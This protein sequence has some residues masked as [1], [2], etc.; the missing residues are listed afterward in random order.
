MTMATLSLDLL[1]TF[2]EIQESGGFSRAAARLG[3]TQS[4]VSLQVQRLEAAV[5]TPLFRRQGKRR[6]LTAEGEVLLHYARRMLALEQQALE[7]V[8]NQQHEG[9]VRIGFAQDFAESWLPAALAQ[10]ARRH[11]KVALDARVDRNVALAQGIE[12]GTLDVALAL[13]LDGRRVPAADVLGT[14]PVVWI[15][16]R[17]TVPEAGPLPLVLLSQPCIFRDRA[18]RA[19]DR[20]GVPWQI[21]VTSHSLSGQWSAVAA[22][23]GVTVRTPVGLPSHLR[24][25]PASKRLPRLG[26]TDVAILRRTGELPPAAEELAALVEQEGRGRLPW[27]QPSARRRNAR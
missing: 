1:Q 11:P 3:R 24:V 15:G 6:V 23:L 16:H 25:L 17:H 19:L 26:F 10:F 5:G 8:G 27:Q 20:A 2:A 12:A 22:G 13:A 18:L 7:A 21:V 4:A 9:P 14:L